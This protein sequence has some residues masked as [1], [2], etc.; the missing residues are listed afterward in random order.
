M[1]PSINPLLELAVPI[2]DKIVKENDLV[3]EEA[4]PYFELLVCEMKVRLV[5]NYDF[6]LPELN[7]EECKAEGLDFV[8]RIWKEH[9]EYYVITNPNGLRYLSEELECFVLPF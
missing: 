4:M 3:T 5:P 1:S 2:A 7:E 6:V 9:G 8:K